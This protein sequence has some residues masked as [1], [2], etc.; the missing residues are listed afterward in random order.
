VEWF[1][2]TVNTSNVVVWNCN[3]DGIDTDQSWSGTLNNFVVI[4]VTGH[5]FELDGPEG[6][7]VDGHVITNGSVKMSYEGRITEDVINTDDN[8]V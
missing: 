7:F 5:A 8:S 1:G 3:V 4:G 6:S 2:G